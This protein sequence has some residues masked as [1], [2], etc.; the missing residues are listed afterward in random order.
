MTTSQENPS[1]MKS[2]KQVGLHVHSEHSFLDG[3]SKTEQIARRVSELGQ[4]AVALTDHGEVGGHL[5]FG[6]MCEKFGVKALYGM[7]GYWTPNIQSLRDEKRYRE[8]SHITLIAQNKKGLSN[9]WAWSSK[10]YRKENFY[11]KPLADPTLM[12]EHSEGI[13]ASDGCL[14]T[15]FAR[16]VLRGDDDVAR[17][18]LS[19]LLGVF[20]DR[21]FMELHTFQIITPTTEED[22]KLNRE[23]TELNQAKV[24][25]AKEMGI[26]LVVVNDAHYSQPEHWENHQLVWGMGT[27]TLDQSGKGQAAAHIMGDEELYFWMSK[28]GIS[29]SIVEEAINNSWEIA[30][31]CEDI[32][33]EKT[34]EMPRLT[35]SDEDDLKL[36][37]RQVEA[38]F[39]RKVEEAGLDVEVYDKRMREEVDLITSKNFSGYFNIVADYCKAAKTGSYLE[40]IGRE[41]RPMLVGPSRG[42]AGGS[43]VA[44][45]MDITEIDP[46]KYDLLFGRFLSPSRK[47]Y[48][49]I[50]LDFEQGERP[51]IK[52]Y[53]SKKYGGDDH[54]CAIGTRNYTQP[55][56]ALADLC[57][58]MGVPWEDK[59]QIT[60]IIAETADIDTAN[61]K[62]TW[63]MVRD[64]QSSQLAPWV[65]KYPKLFEKMDEM[66][67]IVRQSSTHAAGL[68]ISSTPLTGNLPTRIKGEMLSTQ[69]DMYETEDLGGIKFDLLGIRHLDTLHLSR[70]LIRE[71][72]GVDLDYYNFGD[73]EFLDPAI[74]T[75]V[76]D[77]DTL[78]LFQLETKYMSNVAR[79][80]KPRSERDVADLI[81]VNRPGV[82]R[83]GMLPTYLRRRAGEEEVELAHPLL[84]DIT[85]RTY[86]IVVF[87]EQGLRV[88]QQLAEFDVDEAENVR[89]IMGKMLYD[90]MLELEPKFIEGCLAN[91][92]FV[93]QND[94]SRWTPRECA[95]NIWEQLKASGV[96]SFNHCLTG[97]TT[98]WRS[99]SGRNNPS[100][101]IDLATLHEV[102]HLP[103]S[104]RDKRWQAGYWYRRK[105]LKILGRDTDGRIRPQKMINIVESGVQDV[106]TVR[107]ECGREISATASHRHLTESGWKCVSDLTLNDSLGVVGDYEP[108]MT[109]RTSEPPCLH[110]GRTLLEE[111][112]RR[113]LP[114][115]CAF[116]GSTSGRIEL[117]HLDSNPENW[118][119]D[120][121][122]KL[123]NSCHK[124]LDYRVG[125]RKK[126]WSKGRSLEFSRVVAIEYRG[127]EMTYDVEMDSEDHS[128]AANG[129]ITHNSHAIGYALIT[130]WEVWVRH[131]Y[132][133]EFLAALLVTD[134]EK[135]TDYLKEAR[136]KDVAIL[137]PDI[138]ESNE[139]FT[140]VGD[141]IRYGFDTIKQVGPTAIK[142]ILSKRPFTS[143]EDFLER[144][145]GSGAKKKSPAV[146]LIKIGAFDCFGSRKDLLKQYYDYK[147]YETITPKRQREWTE[148]QIAEYTENY[149][150]SHK[151]DFP[152]FDFDS[153]KVVYEIEKELVG[154]WI[155]RDPMSVYVRMIENV[156]IQSPDEIENKTVGEAFAVGGQITKLKKHTTKR[157]KP[158]A[159][160]EITWNDEVYSV[161]V[162]PEAWEQCNLFLKVGA[163][164]AC[165]C[166][167]LDQGCHLSSVER[168]DMLE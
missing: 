135:T 20:G 71:R 154:T 87:Q 24:R 26:P 32:K 88:V 4:Q 36:F 33:L 27:N 163:P 145:S 155:T 151:E 17:Q 53:L 38:G 127:C 90:K 5:E 122:R 159:F 25:F 40:F 21:F 64:E 158:M 57:R 131:Y 150:R 168:L 141:T 10:A 92:E 130:S 51:Y 111:G 96:Y 16:N 106:W 37:L 97:D 166:I 44:F 107:L 161:T 1:V 61:M 58:A 137:P 75:Q 94:N 118:D 77:N 55:K 15:E 109:P 147:I 148:Q 117:A 136:R 68:L 39:K 46:L 114:N 9:L 49:D 115:E 89:K 128:F 129:V 41:P 56:G 83:A 79:Q 156:C 119:S 48:P 134:G 160:M 149:Y 72:H 138:N 93:A 31:S 18:L 167:K 2:S 104:E 165:M 65:S 28:H 142:D 153:E 35:G 66:T 82:V 143:F 67:G 59:A 157:G 80:F 14:L 144:A 81:S 74:W 30:Q 6:K 86:G 47:D 164:V 54:V 73:K 42:S 110:N 62:V 76:D 99:T 108:Y 69:F 85:G 60:K 78:G 29:R 126:R 125:S 124:K 101:H 139:K 45:L 105:G 11:Y 3:F 50:D 121:I 132:Y 23:M 12:K 95:K 120:N 19:T 7:E 22:Y 13:Y 116:C 133:L 52:E 70:R 102:W 162:F 43:L 63:E 113:D 140:L 100:V 98:V 112:Y 146:A 123:C 103:M 34:L 152:F 91:P 8:N 84:A